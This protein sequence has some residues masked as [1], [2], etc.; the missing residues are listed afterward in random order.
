VLESE[1]SWTWTLIVVS[2]AASEIAL[3][4]GAVDLPQ[5]AEVRHGAQGEGGR[6]L[7]LDLLSETPRWLPMA[8]GD[9]FEVR[10]ALP[11]GAAP[12]ESLVLVSRVAHGYRGGL[13]AEALPKADACE[14]D[15]AC[16]VADSWRDEVRSAA[17]Y[18]Y[19]SDMFIYL[20]SGQ[21]VM[22]QPGSFRPWLLT[23]D[24]CGVGES[25]DQ[26]VIVYWNDQASACGGPRDGS[27]DQT[28]LGA[29]YRW[30]DRISD[31]M[32]MELLSP[33]PASYD[34][35]HAGWDASD[36]DVTGVVGIHHPAGDE[37][38]ISVSDRQ[39]DH[40]HNCIASLFLPDTHW[41][42]PGW[43]VGVTEGG[44]SGSA[45]W[46]QSDH[47]IVGVLSGGNSFCDTPAGLDCYGRLAVAWENGLDE[48]LDPNATGT[49]AVSGSNPAV[50]CPALPDQDGDGVGD[51]C[52][53]CPTTADPDQGDLDADGQGD[54][55]DPC[56]LHRDPVPGCDFLY[57]D[58]A[59]PGAPDGRVDVADVLRLLRVAVDLEVLT[60][61]DFEAANLAPALFD[62]EVPPVASPT[63]ESPRRLD[64][65]DVQLI[66]RAG[67]GLLSFPAPS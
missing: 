35:F 54:A 51:D 17:R 56:R 18:T 45:I 67:V 10:L 58:L 33:P 12:D 41:L 29:V 15:V 53:V 3:T 22:D 32:L 48:W 8:S 59:P 64:I 6:S 43:D 28:Q 21:L 49:L 62:D 13:A 26:D 46:S 61:R 34:V 63:G 38:S 5:G 55:C 60:G 57:G 44:S 52:D 42:V 27:H 24:H 65:S 30:A 66:L 50:P 4:L 20:C 36:A 11:V 39:L 1:G 40:M 47:R 25:N 37:K 31:T 16:A 19:P 23:A 14:V 9:A 2:P 7:E